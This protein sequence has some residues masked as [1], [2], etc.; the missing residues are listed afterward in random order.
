M[1]YDEDE[2]L[3]ISGIQHFCFCKRQWALI[4]M[5]QEWADDGR[6]VSGDLFHER[7]DT[8]S[9]ETRKG[10]VTLRSVRVSSSSL[11]LSGR[12]DVVEIHED[13]DGFHIAGRDGRYSVV[14]VE[15]K[16]GHRKERDWDR[17][18]LC[19][20]SMALEESLDTTVRTGCLFYGSERRREVV[21]IDDELREETTR[22]AEE[23]H[24]ISK[25]TTIPPAV[26]GQGCKKCS[27][28]DLCMP[29]IDGSSDVD[30]YYRRM[31]EL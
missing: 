8:L 10:V 5:E 2:Y 17:V 7:V 14:P 28:Y 30:D 25:G 9:R 27:L 16:V 11:G 21:S 22:L 29:E 6:T 19:A 18:Q 4:H 23:M 1:T 15:Y 12:C 24:R 26:R 31:A 13:P 3:M 20:E